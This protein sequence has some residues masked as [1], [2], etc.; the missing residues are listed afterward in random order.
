MINNLENF[1]LLREYLLGRITDETLVSEIEYKLLADKSF[2]NDFELVEDELIE[3]YVWENLSE[4]D[5]KDF[6]R[7]F[8][9]VPARVEKI[10]FQRTLV[11]VTKNEP[12]NI[13]EEN[14]KKL[15]LKWLIFSPQFAIALTVILSII[16]GWWFYGKKDSGFD[17]RKEIAAMYQNYRPVKARIAGFDYS[18]FV[19]LRGE[20][21]D[22]KDDK[23][24]QKIENRLKKNAEEIADDR[25]F[26]DLCVF[27]L[28]E[29]KFDAAVEKCAQAVSRNPANAEAQSD[30]GAAL[31]ENATLKNAEEKKA[32][33]EKSLE[34]SVKALELDKTR[35]DARFNKALILTELNLHEQAIAAWNEYL[36]ND[37]D[38]KWAV[39]AS[40]NLKKITESK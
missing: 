27:Y 35:N 15:S 23:L 7:L 25:A 37:P 39:E 3:D 34:H 13:S 18:P 32:L 5:L 22:D 17:S 24:N 29:Q 8:L 38:S 14:E 12:L 2:L 16:G 26:N 9:P 4:T 11:S 6:Q 31:F 10:N 36:Q 30:L 20:K 40:D 19:N 33:L 28:T 1:N 21:K